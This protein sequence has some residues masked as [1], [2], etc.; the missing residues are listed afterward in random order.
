M[1]LCVMG[2]YGLYGDTFDPHSQ[3]KPAADAL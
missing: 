3:S 1:Y 2:V